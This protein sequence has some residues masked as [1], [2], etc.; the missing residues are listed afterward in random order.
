LGKEGI[1]ILPWELSN[2]VMDFKVDKTKID[3]GRLELRAEDR[4]AVT[5]PGPG[6]TTDAVPADER[7]VFRRES[8]R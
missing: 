1:N 8:P 5:Q 4:E 6:I 7:E 2:Q 3:S